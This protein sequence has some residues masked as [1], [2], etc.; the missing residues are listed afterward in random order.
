MV[1][2]SLY[3]AFDTFP[4]PKGAATHIR[5]VAKTLFEYCSPGCLYVMGGESLP[6]YQQEP[7]CEI[8]RFS[9]AVANVFQRALAFSAQLSHLLDS[10]SA[11]L[12]I[13]H[14]RDP[15]SGYPIL[16]YREKHK[17]E[18]KTLYEVNALPSI[19]LPYAYPHIAPSTIDKIHAQ[20]TLCLRHAD[21]IITPSVTTAE[22][23]G[24]RGIDEGKIQVIPNG[25]EILASL[26]RPADA[27]KQY[28]IYFGSI[29][30]WQGVSDLF[31]AF[32]MLGDFQ[33]LKLLMC[34]SK[35]NRIA[36]QYVKLAENLGIS[37]RIVWKYALPKAE[38]NAWVEH[39]EFS[40]AP[41]ADC[42]RN[43]LQ[44]CCPLKILESMAA[45]VPVVA[46]NLPV[47]REIMQDGVHGC[48]VKPGRAPEL[49]LAMRSLLE[50]PAVRKKMGELGKKIV[51]EKLNWDNANTQ[52]IKIYNN[53]WHDH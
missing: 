35:Y 23:L 4:A 31:R 37:D 6:S 3:A 15:W 24:S 49:A 12:E 11:H 8:N 33:N 36:K 13:C 25:A 46:S 2:K 39:A 50:E 41:L 17:C 9:H 40:L 51:T 42:D 29:Q 52:L 7:N 21:K 30:K 10:R 1:P 28:L 20:E 16:S 32:S 18:F 26:P 19:E 43:T 34:V 14:F 27:P 45:G 47:V 5:H 44:G 48:L 38:L 53:L 22:L